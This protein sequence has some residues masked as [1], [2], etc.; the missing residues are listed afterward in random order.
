MNVVVP[1]RDFAGDAEPKRGLSVSLGSEREIWAERRRIL[2]RRGRYVSPD[3]SRPGWPSKFFSHSLRVFAWGA[4]LFAVHARGKHN[5][6]APRL[7]D[8]TVSFPNLPPSFDGYRILHLSDTHLDHLPELAHVAARML[9]GTEVDLLVLTGDV[10]GHHRAPLDQ[11]VA[12]LALLLAGIVVRE[13][14]LAVLGNHDPGD[15]AEA[16][17]RLGFTVLINGSLVLERR[18]QRVVV[19]GLDDVHRFYTAAASRAL[20]DAPR[21][22]RIAL[23]HSG[24]MADHAA[25]AGYALYLCGHTHGGQIC[26]P[27][28]R[29]IFTRLR[30]CHFAA[31][32]EWRLGQMVGYTSRGLGISGPPLRYNCQGDISVITLR[33]QAPEGKAV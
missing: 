24:E 33:R 18:G 1:I 15:M 13:R 9:S 11:S 7:L 29:P 32:G 22:F 31:Q 3:G 30:R 12:P 6:L 19:T 5:A 26:W 28:G 4:R 10:H 2:E 16:L 8:L 20:V 25:S 21:G 23:V 14:Q 17:E 27:N